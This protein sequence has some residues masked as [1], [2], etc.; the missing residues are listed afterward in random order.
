MGYM[1]TVKEVRNEP[2]E[3]L[4]MKQNQQSYKIIRQDKKKTPERFGDKNLIDY[5]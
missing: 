3:N 5:V 4:M 1:N 2:N